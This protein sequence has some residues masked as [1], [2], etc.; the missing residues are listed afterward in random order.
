MTK[1]HTRGNC[2]RSIIRRPGPLDLDCEG[3]D[4]FLVTAA[5]RRA[6]AAE[7]AKTTRWINDIRKRA[8]TLTPEQR[9]QAAKRFK[10]LT[11]A[12][13]PSRADRAATRPR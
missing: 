12:A 13:T 10:A 6:S 2:Y 11:A 4:A 7:R 9:R 3:P 8:A 5:Q 1:K